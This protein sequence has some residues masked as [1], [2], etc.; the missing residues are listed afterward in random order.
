MLQDL[1]LSLPQTV[2][3]LAVLIMVQATGAIAGFWMPAIAPAVGR[4]LGLDPAL[5]AYPVLIIYI[6][7]MFSSL[8]AEG[9]IAR[10]GAWRTSQIALVI[11]AASHLVIMAGSLVAIAIG[12]LVLGVGYG[13]VTPAA[14]QILQRLVTPENR[15]LIFSIRFTGVP[16]GGFATGLVAPAVTLEVGWQASMLVTVFVAIALALAMQPLRGDWD[17]G[18]QSTSRLMRNPL[19]DLVMVWQLAPVWWVALSGFFLAAIQTTLTTYTVTMLVKDLGYGLVAA[20]MGLSAVQVASVFGR[21]TWGWLADRVGN[22]L[23]VI[24]TVALVAAGCAALVMTMTATWSSTAVLALC[25]AYGFVGMSWN[26][27]YASEVA[28]LAPAGAVG[29]VTG[30][31]MFFAFSG[32]LLG[33]VGFVAVLGFAESYTRAFLLTLVVA[34]AAMLC[35]VR[36]RRCELRDNQRR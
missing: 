36:A 21:L 18:R 2:L 23:I 31:C 32:V 33:P 19:A 10:F 26:G 1:R 12:S 3:A 27:V 17:G 7:A 13:L 4:S 20:G 5:I 6:A 14:S 24:G 30:A 11:F 22:G 28:R 29:R 35:I 34:L 16:L 9:L 25:F 15:N 8:A